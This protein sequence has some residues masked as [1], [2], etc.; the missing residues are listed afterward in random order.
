[1]PTKYGL[2][3]EHHAR[4]ILLDLEQSKRD[5][6]AI[7]S[8]A[9]GRVR[10]GVGQSLVKYAEEAL[11][12]L[13]QRFP[14]ANTTIITDYAE[15]LK[16]SL[17]ENRIDIFLGMVNGLTDDPDFD[18]QIVAA[19]P[20]VGLCHRS[21]AFAEQTVSL[22]ELRGKEWLVPE[23][24]EAARSA[25][26]AFFL[27]N[28]EPMPR[29]KVVTNIASVVARFV[30][31]FHLLSVAPEQNVDDYAKHDVS[32]F[33]IEGFEFKRQVGIVQRSMYDPNPLTLEFKN[34]L[35]RTLEKHG[36]V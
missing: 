3:L 20:I 26:E 15:G 24:G 17:L 14:S 19:D 25:L 31:D 10:L 11:A 6:T 22:T 4:R 7:S 5:L 21:H 36:L 1:M 9:S 34:I 28:Q 27:I 18:I 13:L 23:H 32:Q 30:R 16:S 35:R 29:I 33:W 12:E 2:A 8:G